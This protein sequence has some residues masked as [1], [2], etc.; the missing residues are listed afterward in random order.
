MIFTMCH[1]SSKEDNILKHFEQVIEDVVFEA[2]H[3]EMVVMS[4][5]QCIISPHE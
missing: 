2:L 5:P 1:E 3:R 4:C